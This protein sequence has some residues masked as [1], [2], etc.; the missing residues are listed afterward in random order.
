MPQSDQVYHVSHLG[1]HHINSR[2]DTMSETGAQ[3]MI[4][5]Q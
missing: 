5:G 2:R 4:S 3:I 1:P